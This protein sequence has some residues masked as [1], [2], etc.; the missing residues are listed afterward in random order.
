MQKQLFH[1]SKQHKH[2]QTAMLSFHDDQSNK[3]RIFHHQQL[4]TRDVQ[5]DSFSGVKSI[6]SITEYDFICS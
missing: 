1:Y 4:R 3:S 5:D 2:W 6:D